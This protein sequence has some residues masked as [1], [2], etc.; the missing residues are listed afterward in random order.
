V[1][2]NYVE[3][4]QPLMVGQSEEMEAL[5]T[6]LAMVREQA[7]EDVA[8]MRG[9]VERMRA[10]LADAQRVDSAALIAQEAQRQD[11]DGLRRALT[12]RQ[13][14]LR[15][16][17]ESRHGLEDAL[18]DAHREV[19]NLRREL[20][21]LRGGPSSALPTDSREPPAATD[22]TSATAPAA[23]VDPAGARGAKSSGILKNLFRGSV[24]GTP[25]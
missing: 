14:E 17:D 25:S 1:I 4:L 8:Q 22:P 24:A 23:A 2:Q 10:R 9:E 19:D 3:Q 7:H 16:A 18:E 11:L 21:R 20:T 6:E 5:R 12:E 15:E 13:R